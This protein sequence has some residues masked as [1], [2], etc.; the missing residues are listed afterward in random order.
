ML[1]LELR[2]NKASFKT[3]TFNRSGISLIV[4]KRFNEDSSKKNTYN[5]VGKSLV[6]SL[7][8]FC[9][10]TNKNTE[11][12]SK[13]N[14]WIF[15][16]DFEISG[17]KFTSSRACNDQSVL[18]LNEQE[19]TLKDF[20]EFL[21]SKIFDIPEP[22][23]YLTF[24]SLIS[25]FIRPKKSSYV[26]YDKSVDEEQDYARLI[27]NAFLLGLDCDLISKKHDLKDDMDKVDLL[28][29]NIEKDPIMKSFFEGDE[30][31]G[32][33]IELVNLKEKVQKLEINIKDFKIAED[34]Y[35]IVKDADEIKFNLKIHEN[36]YQALQTAISNIEKSLDIQP[37]ISKDKLLKLFEEAEV[38]LTDL[39][40]KQFT[41]VENFN[42]SLIS[43][44]SKRL[45]EERKKLEKQLD[46]VSK[47][48]K[49]L[50]DDKD[51][52]LQYLNTHGALDEYASLNEQLS[53]FKTQLEKMELYKQLVNEYKNRVEELKKTFSDEN[54]RTN[55]YLNKQGSLIQENI[56]LFKSFAEEFYI[57]KKAGVEINNNEGINKA[58]FEIKAK[59]DDD[60]GD[61]V[62]DIK[63]FCF[64]WTILKGQHNHNVKFIFHDSRIL[65]EIDPR[66]IATLFKVANKN[67][68]ESNYQY[69]ISSNENILESLKNEL[70]DEDYQRI[71]TDNIILE[72]TD[73]SDMS[74]LLGMQMDLDYDKE[75]IQ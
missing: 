17:E 55:N 57:N 38:A 25:R 60:K 31:K 27:N 64:D 42:K 58:R 5:S 61:G 49:K 9:L 72:L 47:T 37:D 73:E 18:Q 54:I 34:Y 2:A 48:I 7:I 45:V 46:E 62:N 39:I 4:G 43:N 40:K 53:S 14:D 36:K 29:K 51:E 1:L 67:T 70:G 50:G 8:H 10:A 75:A 3:V 33:E 63:I 15:E 52:K 19:Y 20:R 66:Q 65:S 56:V 28:K 23:K 44:R 59:I 32:V 35:Q 26:A 16:L 30:N 13:L 74:K 69:I 11:F 71:I 41:E 12:E 21:C 22:K 24:R 68:L 6:I